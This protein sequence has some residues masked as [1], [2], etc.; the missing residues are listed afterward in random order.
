MTKTTFR[1]AIKAGLIAGTLDILAAFVQY[2]LRTG[3]TPLL[4]L[5]FIASGVFGPAARTGG[6]PMILLGLVF[7]YIIALSF[8]VLLF[9]IVSR[10]PSLKHRWVVTG[11]VYGLLVWSIMNLMVVPLSRTPQRPLTLEGALIA[12]AILVAC[13][14]LPLAYRA[15]KLPQAA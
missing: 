3:K 14:G 15:R 13:I 2:Y 7:H 10:I 8:A 5:T 1:Q 6:T 12:A 11:I 4:V 9:W